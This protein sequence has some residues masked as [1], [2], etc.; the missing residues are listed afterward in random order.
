MKYTKKE[1]QGMFNRLLIALN[2]KEKT[3]NYY[4]GWH[5]DYVNVYGGY[6]IE[7]IDENGGVDHPFGAIRRNA[8]EMYLSMLMAAQVAEELSY[9]QD[10]LNKYDRVI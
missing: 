5:L 4:I 8:K 9:Q 6:V 7:D 3:E 2:K 10:L 1:V